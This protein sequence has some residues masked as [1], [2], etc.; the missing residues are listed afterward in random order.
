M[1]NVKTTLSHEDTP[2]IDSDEEVE[3]VMQSIKRSR[4]SPLA[5]KP[6]FYT[7]RRRQCFRL[8]DIL[9]DAITPKSSVTSANNN[10][11]TITQQPTLYS[12]QQYP[13]E[14]SFISLN[15]TSHFW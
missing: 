9:L 1:N 14:T 8:K 2:F 5:Q 11:N 15:N 4:P 3:S 6:Y 13:I 7:K 10:N 12:Q